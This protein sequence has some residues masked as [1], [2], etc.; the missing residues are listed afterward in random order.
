M[1]VYTANRRRA[2]AMAR[3]LDAYSLAMACVDYDHPDDAKST[4]DHRREA[5]DVLSLWP[6]LLEMVEP[7]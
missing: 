1:S 7:S 4:E 2:D 6:G 5:L 3:A